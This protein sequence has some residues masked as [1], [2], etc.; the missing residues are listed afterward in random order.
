MES[1]EPDASWVSGDDTTSNLK[2][3]MYTSGIQISTSRE[4]IGEKRWAN[5][6]IEA[7]L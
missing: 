2:I 5:M 7:A 4:S 6:I 3:F 1:H